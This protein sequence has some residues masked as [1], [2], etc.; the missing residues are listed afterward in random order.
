MPKESANT[1]LNQ[2]S[3]GLKIL[4]KITNAETGH[5]NIDIGGGKYIM[6]PFACTP[7]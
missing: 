6:K 1:S 5:V 4:K 7:I 3:S 2:V